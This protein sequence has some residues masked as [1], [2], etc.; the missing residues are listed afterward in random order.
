MDKDIEKIAEMNDDL[1]SNNGLIDTVKFSLPGT[2]NYPNHYNYNDYEPT[3][4]PSLN[5][6]ID[7]KGNKAKSITLLENMGLQD[8][9][10]NH[11]QRTRHISKSKPP[12]APK[13]EIDHNFGMTTRKLDI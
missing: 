8:V 1:S 5:L 9:E 10:N 11:R 2:D 12:S 13:R 6:I 4:L 7:R 3:N